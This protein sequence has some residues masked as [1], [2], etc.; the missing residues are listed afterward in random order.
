MLER[1]VNLPFKVSL[2]NDHEMRAFYVPEL[3]SNALRVSESGSDPSVAV[4]QLMKAAARA[5]LVRR[6]I[7]MR[8][9]HSYPLFISSFLSPCGNGVSSGS[10]RGK[11]S[12]VTPRVSSEL[13]DSQGAFPT[14]QSRLFPRT[15]HS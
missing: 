9:P 15:H 1:S 14:V 10:G 8:I 7:V 4:N 6:I 11:L 12:I 2:G 3:N 13:N 5:Q